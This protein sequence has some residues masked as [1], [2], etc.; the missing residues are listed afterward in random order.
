LRQAA[1]ELVEGQG[2]ASP[3]LWERGEGNA[4]LLHSFALFCGN[5]HMFCFAVAYFLFARFCML[6]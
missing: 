1:P 5:Q 3:T 4:V 2:T 6:P